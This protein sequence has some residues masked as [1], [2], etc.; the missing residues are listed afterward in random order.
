M[1]DEITSGKAYTFNLLDEW[2][3]I[4][5]LSK[6]FDI[7]YLNNRADP[8]MINEYV[9][10]LI[11]FYDALAPKVHSNMANGSRWSTLAVEFDSWKKKGWIDNPTLFQDAGAM[12]AI[13][14]FRRTLADVIEALGVTYFQP[15]RG[16]G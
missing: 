11:T 15:V 3:N 5:V 14:E 8:T 1:E 2:R 13:K 4:L 9:G 10:T 6:T 12:D 16:E 7:N